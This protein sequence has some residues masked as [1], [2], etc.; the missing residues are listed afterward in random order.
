[1][2]VGSVVRRVGIFGGNV[3]SGFGGQHVVEYALGI[4]M[5][6]PE[7]ATIHPRRVGRIGLMKLTCHACGSSDGRLFEARERM[8]G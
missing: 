1:M 6:D 5:S 2:V 8:F 4:P 3:G 7:S